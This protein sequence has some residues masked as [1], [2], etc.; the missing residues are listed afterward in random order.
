M[1]AIALFILLFVSQEG[2]TKEYEGAIY[3]LTNKGNT[4]LKIGMTS[5]TVEERRKELSSATGV[6]YPFQIYFAKKVDN[7]K[8]IEKEL[9]DKFDKFRVA[10][11]KEFF[12]IEPESAYKALNEVEGLIIVDKERRSNFT[13]LELGIKIGAE[14]KFSEDKRRVAKVL[15]DNL[16][17][18][19]KEAY[20]LSGLTALLLEKTSSSG[21]K[22]L[23]YWVYKD[24]LLSD[25]R[26][27]QGKK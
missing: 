11:G 23:D 8:E 26:E 24:E 5:R 1:R 19:K 12:D 15:D 9:H 25:I 13:F 7:Y 27:E 14:L 4:Y 18:Y 10:S 22:A 20:S 21:I 16:V 3:I 2:F 17:M 6:P